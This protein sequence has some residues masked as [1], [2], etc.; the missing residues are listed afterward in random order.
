MG[1]IKDIL[2]DD[3]LEIL[4]SAILRFSGG[5][6]LYGPNIP[7]HGICASLSRE[8]VGELKRRELSNARNDSN[9]A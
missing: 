8:M 3:R 9:P 5:E 6:G 1:R 7:R 4:R 2:W